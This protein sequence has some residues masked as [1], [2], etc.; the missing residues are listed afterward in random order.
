[1]YI[2]IILIIGIWSETKCSNLVNLVAVG[3]KIMELTEFDK[4][5]IVYALQCRIRQVKRTIARAEDNEG[6]KEMYRVI[7]NNLRRTLDKL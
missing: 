1:M 4:T 7:L 2:S 6:K 5:T 3:K